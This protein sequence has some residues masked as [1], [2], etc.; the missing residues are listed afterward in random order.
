MNYCE[1]ADGANNN[2]A[3]ARVQRVPSLRAAVR[4]D[5]GSAE[6][7]NRRVPGLW[8]D[9]RPFTPSVNAIWVPA[10]SDGV[11]SEFYDVWVTMNFK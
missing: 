6:P 2:L 7:G 11:S 1:Y 9:T 3:G 8:L 4:V 10:A 5:P